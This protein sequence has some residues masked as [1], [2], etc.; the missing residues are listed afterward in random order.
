MKENGR[1]K[2]KRYGRVNKTHNKG[3]KKF[4]LPPTRG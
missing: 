2:G 3:N 4:R 1:R